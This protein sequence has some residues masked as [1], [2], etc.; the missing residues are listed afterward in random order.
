M[1]FDAPGKDE[2][3]IK[4][5]KIIVMTCTHAALRR[6]KLVKLGFKYDNM[7]MEEAAQILEVR[8]SSSF[9]FRIQKTDIID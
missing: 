2:N 5:A 7:V 3:T 9:S 8:H 4:Q 1:V 6:N